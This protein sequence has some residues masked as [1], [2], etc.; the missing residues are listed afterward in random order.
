MTGAAISMAQLDGLIMVF[1]GHFFKGLHHFFKM[2]KARK[3]ANKAKAEAA[4]NKKE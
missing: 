3:K 2:G 4:K 1:N